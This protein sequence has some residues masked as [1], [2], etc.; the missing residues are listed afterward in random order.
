MALL[1][2]ICKINTVKLIQINTKKPTLETTEKK[3][4]SRP[5]FVLC[6]V[7]KYITVMSFINGK[8]EI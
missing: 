4:Q 5:M 8:K 1:F 7:I 3:K 2:Q 6:V